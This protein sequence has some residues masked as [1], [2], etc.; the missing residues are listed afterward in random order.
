LKINTQDEG[1]KEVK[2]TVNLLIESDT[3][4][5]TALNTICAAVTAVL[6]MNSST[7]IKNS[8]LEYIYVHRN[9]SYI[10]ES[11]FD[12]LE[13]DIVDYITLHIRSYS[14]NDIVNTIRF[15]IYPLID[16]VIIYK[17]ETYLNPYSNLK[18]LFNE[19]FPVT[20]NEMMEYM[21]SI[22]LD[23]LIHD[24]DSD[25]FNYYTNDYIIKDFWDRSSLNLHAN[26]SN[27]VFNYVSGSADPQYNYGKVF[28]MNDCG[29]TFD[30]WFS[31][32]GVN[33]LIVNDV[34]A[35]FELTFVLNTKPKYEYNIY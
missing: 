30:I 5:F 28:V 29:G 24:T 15:T 2:D 31:N 26:F 23:E 6:R 33:K 12:E 19:R 18:R 34:A 8:E 25:G 14:E 3:S 20:P 32:D 7:I 11:N 4:L 10:N 13:D 9:E 21:S 16:H 27:N 35:Q 1:N 17:P 22:V